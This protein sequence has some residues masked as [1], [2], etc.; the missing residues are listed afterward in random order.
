MFCLAIPPRKNRRERTTFTRTQLEI[1]EN[2]FTNSNY[3][4]VYL[5]EK[6]ANQVQLAESRIQVCFYFC[7][8]EKLIIKKF[9]YVLITNSNLSLRNALKT[10]AKYF[11]P[12]KFHANTLFL[13]NVALK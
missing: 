4:D 5:R 10:I 12:P 11:L 6:I 7:Q 2:H 13:L 1:L 8:I 3:P 9:I